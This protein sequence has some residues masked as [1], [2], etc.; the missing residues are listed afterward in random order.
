MKN[1]A[2]TR[3]LIASLSENVSVS[4]PIKHW[5]T[6]AVQFLFF[7]IVILCGA[8]FFELYQWRKD[9]FLVLREGSFWAQALFLFTLSVASLVSALISFYPGKSIGIWSRIA[10]YSW[11]LLVILSFG[12]SVFFVFTQTPV[13]FYPQLEWVCLQKLIVVSLFAMSALSLLTR[14]MASTNPFLSSGFI[15]LSSVSLGMLFLHFQCFLDSWFHLLLWHLLPSF[16]ICF[17]ARI[18]LRVALR[19]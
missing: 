11:W 18:L 7:L 4:P 8:Y 9:L 10:S 17:L 19:W 15:A 16:L 14:K 12:L 5:A 13:N 2:S 6:Y 3:Q 1:D